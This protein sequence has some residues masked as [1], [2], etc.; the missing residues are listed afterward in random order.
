MENAHTANTPGEHDKFEVL[1][2]SAECKL[3]NHVPV[4]T[5]K[6]LLL[7]DADNGSIFAKCAFR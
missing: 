4:L 3:Q 5:E 1:Y 2:E 6:V 7:K